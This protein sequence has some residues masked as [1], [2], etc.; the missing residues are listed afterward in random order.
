MSDKAT[1]KNIFNQID[2]LLEEIQEQV[3]QSQLDTSSDNRYQEIISLLPAIEN[4]KH[5]GILQKILDQAHS[6]S[7]ESYSTDN[8]ISLIINWM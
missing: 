1:G 3:D 6:L 8:H 2:T 7:K 4:K 5:R